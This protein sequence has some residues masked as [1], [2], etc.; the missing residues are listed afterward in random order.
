MDLAQPFE[1]LTPTADGDALAVLAG[2]DRAF[3]ASEVRDIA[4]RRSVEGI[5]HALKRLETQGIVSS[6]RA[7]NTTLYRLNRAHLAAGPAT[8]I[9]NMRAE[10][11]NRIRDHLARWDP[12]CVHAA[13]FGSAA[14]GEMQATSDIDVFLVRP[15][16]V[17]PD[18]ERWALQRDQIATSIR[19]WT[20]N[21]ARI[22]ELSQVEVTNEIDQEHSVL[23][24]V[25]RDGIWLGGSRTFLSALLLQ[26]LS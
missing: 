25:H 21:D 17:D 18:D 26:P 6:Q 1:T 11:F 8:A 2:A 9:A 3:T 19:N 4:G 12:P 20:G 13:L 5:R 15:N 16:V 22:L 14:R 23:R 7:G 10:L 24:D